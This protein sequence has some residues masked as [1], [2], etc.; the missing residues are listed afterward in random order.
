MRDK[1]EHIICLNATES[2]VKGG[3]SKRIAESTESRLLKNVK[4]SE[5]IEARMEELQDEKILTQ[6]QILVMLSEIESGQAEGYKDVVI[7]VSEFIKNPNTE[8]K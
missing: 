6:K 3:Y 4:V 5:Y 1:N 7:K 8:K 2:A